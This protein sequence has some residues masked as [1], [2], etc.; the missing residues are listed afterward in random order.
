VC[1]KRYQVTLHGRGFHVPV[2]GHKPITG[3][4]AIRRVIAENA[5]EAKRTAIETLELEK[6]YQ[7]LVEITAKELGFRN[8]CSVRL[9]SIGYLSWFR[10]H[11][12]R[13]S[14]SLI[15]YQDEAK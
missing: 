1:R 12:S 15:F 4:F 5:D 2:E 11:F 10:W 8:S 14:P 9:D 7:E 3:F 6:R 13:H